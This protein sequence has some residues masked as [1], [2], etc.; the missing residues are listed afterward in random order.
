MSEIELQD[1]I[2][3]HSLQILRLSA[4][5]QAKVDE[6][7]LE[8]EK[9]LKALLQSNT[10]SGAGKRQ[11]EELLKEAEKAI[12]ASYTVAARTTDTH[13]L[14]VVVAEHTVEA[15]RENFPVSAYLPT[16]ETLASLTRDVLI[17]GAP[18]S[19]WWERQS[20]DTAFRFAA[21]VR[22]GVI[23]GETQEKIVARIAGR[24][25]I[26]EVSRR[27]ARSLVHS[28][29]MTAANQARLTTFRKNSRTIKGV[30]Y[31]ATLDGHA[32]A[33]CAA[34]DGQSWNLDGE[35]LPGTTV[36]FLPP[37]L[38]FGCFPEGTSVL[39]RRAITGASKRWFDGE[40]VVFK[41]AAGRELTCTPNHPILTD[42]GWVAAELLNV[43][44]NVIC[45]GGSEWEGLGH[46]DGEH[47]PTGIHH[48]TEAFFASRQMRAMPV[49]VSP[50][51]F[52]GDGAGSEIAVVWS[53]GLLRSQIDAPCY[54]HFRQSLLVSGSLAGLVGFTARS[55]FAPSLEGEA[56]CD[57][58][59]SALSHA[60]ADLRASAPHPG[61]LLGA[62]VAHRNSSF[63]EFGD[64]R[65]PS[66]TELLSNPSDPDALFVKLDRLAEIYDTSRSHL[67]P[68][69]V[70]RTPQSCSDS[71]ELHSELLGDLLA[72][73]A[74][75]ICRDYIV[76][77]DRRAFHGYVYNLET[78][79]G[80]Y[81][82]QGL[83]VHN[84]RCVL[85]PIPKTFRDIGLNIDEPEDAGQ[86]ASSL[87]PVHGKTTFNDYFGRL[88]KAQQDEQFGPVRAQMWRDGKITI[89]DLVSGTGR[90][91]TIEEL[92]P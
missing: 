58:L 87:G 10:L 12:D 51:D 83:L 26:M 39:S 33:R 7:L 60:L 44:S 68:A 49:E 29:V 70:A 30:R 16:Q 88:T 5:D 4:G 89:R 1:A 25:G 92:T 42:S 19:A 23:N 55:S 54:K 69:G 35:K 14:A 67:G 17:E 6:V 91:L 76:S 8:L 59:A 73:S 11:I 79:G 56:T 46:G 61:E 24:H 74:G 21:Q 27:N 18:S 64:D 81:I 47:V 13:A 52:H 45:D 15:L 2:L 63:V 9:E 66:D 65:I 85:S 62:S 20:E 28:S 37:P 48:V 36:Q 77:A 50:E 3:R 22:Q 40:V 41:T 34:L 90:E 31:L 78:N 86:R 72:S 80:W 53:D 71:V 32:C 84:C 57:V 43:G 75:Q 38:H 82:A